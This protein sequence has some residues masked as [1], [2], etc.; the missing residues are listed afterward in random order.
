MGRYTSNPIHCVPLMTGAALLG[1]LAAVGFLIGLAGG[2]LQVPGYAEK[3]CVL[4][5]S[6]VL[7][8]AAWRFARIA[9]AD[10]FVELTLDD[11]GLRWRK[12]GR[13]GGFRWDEVK[14]VSSTDSTVTISTRDGVH[15]DV[16]ASL[17]DYAD[18]RSKVEER[19]RE[20]KSRR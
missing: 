11:E 8:L 7:A 9:M 14:T 15:L 18:F 13:S 20:I 4:I 12:P 3:A 19:Y 17:N 16:G 1:F 2:P 6:A 10:Y 5:V